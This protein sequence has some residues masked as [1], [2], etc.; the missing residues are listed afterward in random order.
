MFDGLEAEAR[1]MQG[2]AGYEP[3]I[4]P[5]CRICG[6]MLDAWPSLYGDAMPMH[7]HC[8][9]MLCT[10]RPAVAVSP[11]APTPEARPIA[12]YAALGWRMVPI[13]PMRS[14]RCGCG[15]DP[16][17]HKPGKHPVGWLAPKGV[18]SASNNPATLKAWRAAV[19]D[20]NWAVATG[21]ASG[22]LVV[23]VDGP[24]GDQALANLEAKHGA[25]PPAPWQVTGGGRGG[26]QIFFAWPEG[27]TVKNK[28][29]TLGPKLDLKSAGGYCLISPSITR[30]PYVWQVAPWGLAAPE[31]PAA[32]IDLLDPPAAA[33]AP[34]PAWSAPAGQQPGRPRYARKAF[35]SELALVAC[36]P[37]GRRNDQ[38]NASAHALYRLVA[39][40]DLP[41]GLVLDG[42][43]AAAGH[44]GL[45][46][47][48]ALATISSAAKAR[49]VRR[50]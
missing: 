15:A 21:P 23:D 40:G 41:G 22:V 42:L 39:S 14:G 46:R 28:I 27:R 32:W 48:E 31:L 29:G 18:H 6:E 26:R 45:D 3:S 47:R 7:E 33:P 11:P 36:A 43:T 2:V 24:A 10:E 50:G 16:C 20:L 4:G 44:C 25:L 8:A 35:E 9:L 38:L 17:P 49:G 13:W 37:A 12:R 1:R 19:P 34:R 30:Q 5:R